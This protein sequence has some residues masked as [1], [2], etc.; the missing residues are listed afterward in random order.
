VVKTDATQDS[1]SNGTMIP[2][3]LLVAGL[4]AVVLTVAVLQTA[5]VPVLG[6]IA[7]QLHASTVAASWAVTA[8]LLAALAA[9]PLIGRLADL[10]SKKPVL[11]SVLGTQKARDVRRIPTRAA[12]WS[13]KAALVESFS[14]IDLA[15]AG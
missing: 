13:R 14:N 6:I 1:A 12:A 3:R 8:N 2:P 5:V 10:H 4:S 9:T 11:L 15:N 7:S